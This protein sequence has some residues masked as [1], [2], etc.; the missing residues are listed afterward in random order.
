MKKKFHFL[1][2]FIWLHFETKKRKDF[3][4]ISDQNFKKKSKFIILV[5]KENS[6]TSSICTFLRI[7]VHTVKKYY[8]R[9]VG[10]QHFPRLMWLSRIQIVQI[11]CS[12]SKTNYVSSS[13]V[14]VGRSFLFAHA[15]P[16]MAAHQARILRNAS[17]ARSTVVA[18]TGSEDCLRSCSAVALSPVLC[19]ICSVATRT[20]PNW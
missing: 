18:H 7:F 2:F 1:L 16:S 13:I 3:K 20:S 8:T 10:Q 9:E 5:L 17:V 14:V 4:G 11:F 15:A 19:V 12:T 6:S